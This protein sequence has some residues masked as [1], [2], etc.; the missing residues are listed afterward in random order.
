M[1]SRGVASVNVSVSNRIVSREHR[2]CLIGNKD[3]GVRA[4]SDGLSGLVAEVNRCRRGNHLRQTNTQDAA[5][6]RYHSSLTMKLEVLPLK[7]GQH[8]QILTYCNQYKNS[9]EV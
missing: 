4:S 3:G 7:N 9:K 6:F 2:R 5:W 1:A 8:H